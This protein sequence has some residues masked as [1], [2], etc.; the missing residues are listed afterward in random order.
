MHIRRKSFSDKRVHAIW[1]LSLPAN[2][3]PHPELVALGKAI[4]Q[5]REQHAIAASELAAAVGI[6]PERLAALEAGAVDPAYDLL[7][8]L[9]DGLG[10]RLE[11]LV[12]L[13][14]E[15]RPPAR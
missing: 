6:A 11:Q 14:R 12:R 2:K 15:L 1:E 8:A 10:V 13:A 7:L 3:Q 9:A 5:L 4:E